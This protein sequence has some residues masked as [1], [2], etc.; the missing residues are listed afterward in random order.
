MTSNGFVV[1][2]CVVRASGN[3][4]GDSVTARAR[5]EVNDHVILS[6]AKEGLY[7]N[8]ATVDATLCFPVKKGDTVFISASASISSGGYISGDVSATF[9]PCL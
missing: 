7:G 4:S 5:I 8:S 3:T 1:A 2:S 9:F 6:V